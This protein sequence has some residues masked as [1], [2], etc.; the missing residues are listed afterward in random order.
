MRRHLLLGLAWAPAC[1]PVLGCGIG[2]NGLAGP[3]ASIWGQGDAASDAGE[4][5]DDAVL[6]DTGDDASEAA[7]QCDPTACNGACCGDACVATGCAACAVGGLL[8]ASSTGVGGTCV[9][10]CSSC[11][12]SDGPTVTCYS[13]DDS[14]LSARCAGAASDCPGDLPAGACPC[15]SGTPEQCPGPLQMCALVGSAYVCLTQ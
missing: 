6:T 15:P 2:L 10:S 11:P 13:C 1:V 14:G 7:P 5:G 12:I 9:T 4:G 3:D 8:C